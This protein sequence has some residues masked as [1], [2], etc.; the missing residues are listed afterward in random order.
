ML[1][2]TGGSRV[3]IVEGWTGAGRHCIGV[4]IRYLDFNDTTWLAEWGHPSD[5]LGSILWPSLIVISQQNR[6]RTKAPLTIQR[7]LTTQGAPENSERYVG[8]G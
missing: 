1:T 2:L 5:N 6:A 8:A 7:V 4:L 3:P